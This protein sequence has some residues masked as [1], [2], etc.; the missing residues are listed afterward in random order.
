M[1]DNQYKEVVT[2]VIVCMT[3][4]LVLAAIIVGFFFLYQRR[5]FLQR[6]EVAELQVQFRE[7]SLRAQLEI[8]EQTFRAISEEIHDNVGQLLSL[9]RVQ[10]NIIDVS[11]RLDMSVLHSARE[12]IGNALMELRDLSKSLH[13]DRLQNLSIHEALSQEAER[14]NRAGA[15]QAV[16]RVEGVVQELE[17]QKKLI[18][19]R[20]LQESIQNCLKHADA[21]KLEILFIYQSSDIV[22]R[23]SDNGKGFDPLT[24]IEQNEGQ[25]LGNIRNR[26]RLTG[27]Q[28]EITSAPMNGTLISLT[29][30]YESC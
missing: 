5:K 23:I 18:L 17:A 4:F 29:I 26:V 6:Q 24:A 30:P 19:Y 20:I 14:L 21:T 11:G 27:G 12:N 3:L 9:A 7:Q 28:C 13:S 25:G 22:I 15:V 2:V 16:I 10:I 1:P 8:Q